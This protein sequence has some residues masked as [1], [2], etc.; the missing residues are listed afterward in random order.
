M[1]STS[2]RLAAAS[3][4]YPRYADALEDRAAATFDGAIAQDL[5]RRLGKIA[6]TELLDDARA[7][8]RQLLRS[9]PGVAS[10]YRAACRARS[11]AEF[12]ARIGIALEES[13][14]SSLWF[15][16]ITEGAV[17]TSR[18]AFRLLQESNELSAILAQSCITARASLTRTDRL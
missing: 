2:Y 11:R 7:I 8:R 16:I 4:G 12:V 15:E 6:E 3:G 1:T 13:D 14:E 9:G 17:D 5:W 18:E 10:N